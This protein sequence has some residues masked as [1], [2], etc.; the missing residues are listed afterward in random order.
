MKIIK[1]IPSNAT[2]VVRAGLSVAV[3]GIATTE[4]QDPGTAST[5]LGRRPV[6]AGNDI[7]Q[8]RINR[9]GSWRLVSNTV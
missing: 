5:V 2:Y 9:A 1:L 6:V 3:A 4:V 7:R 8:T